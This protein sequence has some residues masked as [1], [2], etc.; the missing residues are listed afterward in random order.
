MKHPSIVLF[1][2]NSQANREISFRMS[3]DLLKNDFFRTKAF[4]DA[5]I[6]KY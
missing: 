2:K 5:M 4:F 1:V 3:I 6:F